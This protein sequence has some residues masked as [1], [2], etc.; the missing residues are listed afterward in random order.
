MVFSVRL[1]EEELQKQKIQLEKVQV[2]AKLKK[3]EEDL[4]QIED[5]NAKV[6]FCAFFFHSANLLFQKADL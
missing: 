2:E 1:E 3:V 4:V 5:A 6:Y